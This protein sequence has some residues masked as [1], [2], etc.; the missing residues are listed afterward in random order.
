MQSS[1]PHWTDKPLEQSDKS[2]KDDVEKIN[3]HKT[4][5]IGNSTLMLFHR[6]SKK[7][8]PLLKQLKN[9]TLCVT[10]QGSAE[11]P[12]EVKELCDENGIKHLHIDLEGA[13]E[14]LL[15][16]KLTI[17]SESSKL[18]KEKLR[19]LIEMITEN[20]ENVMVHCAA[21]IHRT[22]MFGYTLLRLVA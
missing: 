4:V 3:R 7:T 14:Q 11:K 2:E 19:Q 20:E 21:G 12:E 10:V 13:N 15:A 16:Y 5:P 1:E 8:M 22:G 17:D 9:I 18:L 6:P